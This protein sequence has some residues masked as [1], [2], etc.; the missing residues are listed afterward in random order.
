M[1]DV[2]FADGGGD[3]A[4]GLE[5]LGDGGLLGV[6][7]DVVARKQNAGDAYSWRVAAGHQPGAGRRAD[8]GERVKVGELHSLPGHVVEVGRLDGLRAEDAD[9]LIAL[10]VHKDQDE[11]RCALGLGGGGQ[12]EDGGQGEESLGQAVGN[13]S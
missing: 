6:Q 7:P 2:P 13:D 4:L 8:R 12:H 10:V 9:V 1:A 11:V 5:H 3:V